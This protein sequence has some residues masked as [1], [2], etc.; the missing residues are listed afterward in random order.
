MDPTSLEVPNHS[1]RVRMELRLNGSV[2]TIS[3][4]GPDYLI[5]TEPVDHPPARAEI[6]MS[7]DGNQSHWPVRLPAGLSVAS[8]RT[9][10]LPCLAESDRS[11]V[12]SSWSGDDEGV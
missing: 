9:R 3:H 6:V 7:I 12:E 2:L 10:I 4:L 11:P 1:A 8:R 5:L